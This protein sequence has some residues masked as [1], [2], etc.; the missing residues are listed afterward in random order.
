MAIKIVGEQVNALQTTGE[1]S[2][3]VQLNKEAAAKGMNEHK[4]EPALYKNISDQTFSNAVIVQEHSVIQFEITSRGKFGFGYRIVGGLELDS[5][6]QVVTDAQPQVIVNKL[7]CLPAPSAEDRF[8]LAY[9]AKLTDTVQRYQDAS[10]SMITIEGF[11]TLNFAPDDRGQMV[12]MMNC[13]IT[14]WDVLG[15]IDDETDIDYGQPA[16]IVRAGAPLG[17]FSS[18][19]AGIGGSVAAS[20][21]AAGGGPTR[22][23]TSGQVFKNARNIREDEPR[24]YVNF[25]FLIE[26]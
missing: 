16:D 20:R 13:T 12:A 2:V 22:G 15:F 9:N 21:D 3:T 1:L 26:R 17:L 14:S 24:N 7:Y 19:T 10:K 6:N 18:A 11:K 23:E 4:K 5:R 8:K 25:S